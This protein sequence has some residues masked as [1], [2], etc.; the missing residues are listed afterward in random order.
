MLHL[1]PS[2]R[3]ASRD[4]PQGIVKICPVLLFAISVP[5]SRYQVRFRISTG[6]VD[7]KN[8]DVDYIRVYI[9][10]EN[11]GLKTFLLNPGNKLEQVYFHLLIDLISS[12]APDPDT[13]LISNLIPN[14][15]QVDSGSG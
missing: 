11:Q 3:G 13:N 10:N 5:F 12:V 7:E 6:W 14:L 15:I 8:T 2:R 9:Y 4:V 1:F